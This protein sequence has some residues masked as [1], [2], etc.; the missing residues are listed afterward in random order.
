MKGWPM[1]R[2]PSTGNEDIGEK[3][4]VSPE[5][6]FRSG[7]ADAVGA[8]RR[9]GW[10]GIGSEASRG[11]AGLSRQRAIAVPLPFDHGALWLDTIPP[12]FRSVCFPP[13]FLANVEKRC[14][15]TVRGELSGPRPSEPWLAVQVEVESRS[16]A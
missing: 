6:S 8:L 16:L 4:E 12:R 5:V 3:R 13:A 14:R 7:R 9:F 10:T 11:V 15:R 2:G 1:K